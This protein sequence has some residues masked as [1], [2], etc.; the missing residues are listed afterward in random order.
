VGQGYVA[1]KLGRRALAST[2]FE[3]REVLRAWADDHGEQIRLV[4]ARLEEALWPHADPEAGQQSIISA[5]E[6]VQRVRAEV[7]GE[8]GIAL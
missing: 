2:W 4:L 6:R 5:Y 3:H 1:W 8:R 7:F